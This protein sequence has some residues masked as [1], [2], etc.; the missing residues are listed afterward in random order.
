M[1][2]KFIDQLHSIVLTNIS[3]ENFGV[4]KLSELLGLSPSQT[5]RKTKAASGKSVNQYIRELRL[6]KGSELLKETDKS[7]AEISYQVGFSSA[8]Y[9]NK[10][11]RK[12]YDVTPGEFRVSS[13]DLN[14]L[15]VTKKKK[16]F[17]KIKL[18]FF[19]LV[20]LIFFTFYWSLNPFVSKNLPLGNSIASL[21]FQTWRDVN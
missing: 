6:E 4:R 9:F 16:A 12:Y 2:Q 3:D 17:S 20:G 21:S 10:T 11:F 7:I 14:K 1:N 19:V 15:K 5:L 13:S 8:S 18:F